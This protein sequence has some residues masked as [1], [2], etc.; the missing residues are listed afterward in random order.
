[1]IVA[2]YIDIQ[3][4][5]FFNLIGI[6]SWATNDNQS[7]GCIMGQQDVSCY[8]G[9]NGR[10]RQGVYPGCSGLV[11]S[12]FIGKAGED[13]GGCKKTGIVDLFLKQLGKSET[14]VDLRACLVRQAR[15]LRSEVLCYRSCMQK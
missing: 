8:A 2:A 12:R 1:M 7:V 9:R 6:R 5:S 3:A 11:K 15:D 14:G 13:L 10:S 4:D